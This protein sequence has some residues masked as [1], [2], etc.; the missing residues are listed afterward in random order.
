MTDEQNMNDLD[1]DKRCEFRL[2]GQVG[3]SVERVAADPLQG[4]APQID[5]CRTLDVSANGIRA[6]VPNALP[7][8]AILQLIVSVRGWDK[9][10]H[11]VGEVRW[12]RDAP[13]G[14]GG[15]LAGFE[16]HASE[17][18]SIIAWKEAVADLIN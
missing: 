2:W 3:L 14:E 9:D 16:I 11:L 15:W 8:G 5:T 6:W 13:E 4:I 10:F 12:L 18:T 1:A 17:Q 7:V